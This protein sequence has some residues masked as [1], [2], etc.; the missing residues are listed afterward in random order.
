MENKLV[1]RNVRKNYKLAYEIENIR[2]QNNLFAVKQL[3][4][5]VD[6]LKEKVEILEGENFKWF[7]IASKT[8]IL[9]DELFQ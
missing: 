8:E 5:I 1:R 6:Y 2:N 9:K 7:S 3:E 4:S